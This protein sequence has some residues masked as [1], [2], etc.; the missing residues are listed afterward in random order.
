MMVCMWRHAGHVG[1]QEQKHFSPVGTKLY[2]HVYFF[3]TDTPHDRLLTWLQTKN[4]LG[5]TVRKLY[6]IC[7]VM[8][9]SMDPPP[10]APTNHHHNKVCSIFAT[11]NLILC[12][13]K[14]L[15]SLIEDQ[16]K[17]WIHEFLQWLP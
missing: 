3:C 6:T 16:S 11:H 4:F 17:I 5:D 15:C 10:G 7:M 14:H 9:K 1:G 2:F 12:A 13:A 8:V